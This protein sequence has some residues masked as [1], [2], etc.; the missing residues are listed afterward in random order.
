MIKTTKPLKDTSLA[1]TLLGGCPMLKAA[2]KN[3][4]RNNLLINFVTSKGIKVEKE[5]LKIAVKMP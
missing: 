1:W 4:T 2:I 5:R 3:F